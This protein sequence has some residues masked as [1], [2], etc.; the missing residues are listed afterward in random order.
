LCNALLIVVG[1]IGSGNLIPEEYYEGK[2]ILVTHAHKIFN[3]KSIFGTGNKFEK[4]GCIILDDAHA[5]IDAIRE[6]FMVT[7]NKK[8]YSELYAD[9][10]NLFEEDLNEQGEGTVLD[11]IN[12]NDFESILPIPYWS[13]IDKK[14]EV[15]KLLSEYV[16]E[17]FLAFSWSLFRDNLDKCQAFVG[18]N[19]IEIMPMSI[20]VD[21]FGTFSKAG[22]RILMS[23][24]TQDDIF[25]V[26]TLSFSAE[27]VKNPLLTEGQKWSGEK[28][29]LLP[30]LINDSFKREKMVDFFSERSYKFGVV[31]LVPTW[32]KQK[33]YG[34]CILADS[35]TIFSEISDLKK[36]LFGKVLVLAN[37]YDGIDLPDAACRI[38]ILDSLPFFT[39]MNDLY[40]EQCR[41]NNRLVQK[42]IAQK[43]EQG[44][45]R[46]VRG[47]KDYSC[48]LILGADIV[49]FMRNSSTKELFSEQTQKQVEI[50]LQ[51]AKWSKEE[52]EESRIEDVVE[53]INQCL[54]RD[55]GWKEYYKDEMDKISGIVI[56]DDMFH[57]I[58]S[59]KKAEVLYY[60][61]RYDEAIQ[62]LEKLINEIK[63]DKND[64]G[65]YFQLM[66]R[67]K[68]AISKVEATKYQNKAFAL[69]PQLLKPKEGISYTKMKD[70][71][72]SRVSS[73]KK[74]FENFSTYE[75]IVLDVNDCLES[76]SFEL[77]PE[78]FEKSLENIGKL[79][80]FESQRP[81]KLIRKGPDN[82]WC[83]K[84][85]SYI[86]WECKNNVK[87]ERKVIHK[88]EVG[89]MNN[90]CAW[91]EN[92]YGSV[93]VLRIMVIPTKNLAHDADFAYD[94]KIIRKNGLNNLKKNISNYIKEFKD[95]DFRNLADEVINDA[96]LY[97]KLD[98]DNLI[99]LVLKTG[100]K[101]KINIVFER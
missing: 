17:S 40:E 20:S 53:L 85:N 73:I 22:N 66:G 84:S 25:F 46:S 71:N 63:L 6:S 34:N 60:K 65:W 86:L 98:E 58:I 56:E 43:I 74:W 36:G 54:K 101:K 49:K 37:R 50:G 4:A 10:F 44:L 80:G 99:N 42:K 83:I 64:K 89:Q 82:L 55:D 69:N 14:T 27:S 18:S 13:W 72:S 11:I 29:I 62:T 32:K 15:L 95:Y 31:A 76:L 16:K 24:T 3:G 26:K 79:L 41:T 59:E 7:I 87:A 92:E 47:E 35:E 81:D 9:L 19:G 91:F 93:Q 52:V 39:N 96:L 48:I 51:L 97:H 28:M 30:S 45:G 67:Y 88:H 23:A 90:H 77:E 70:I 78:K 38:L 75:D 21:I 57:V 1:T 8:K 94:V 100:K 2:M 61:G 5:C 68:Y 12:G 33:D